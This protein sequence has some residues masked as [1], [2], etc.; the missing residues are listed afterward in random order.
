MHLQPQYWL[1]RDGRTPEACWVLHTTSSA[2]SR[3]ESLLCGCSLD[4]HFA[5]TLS[6]GV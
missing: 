4:E 3:E 6:Q 5:I 2:V 1:G